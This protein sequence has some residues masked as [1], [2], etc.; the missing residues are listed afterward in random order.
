MYIYLKLDLSLES[1][2]KNL[3]NN[4]NDRLV[5]PATTKKIIPGKSFNSTVNHQDMDVRRENSKCLKYKSV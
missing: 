5:A 1:S 3:I 2:R 4:A